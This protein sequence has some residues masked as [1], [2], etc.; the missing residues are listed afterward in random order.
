MRVICRVIGLPA[1]DAERLVDLV[2][3]TGEILAGIVDADAM[4]RAADAAMQ[5]GGYLA[6][7]LARAVDAAD[8]DGGTADDTLNALL[9]GEI[10]AGAMTFEEAAGILVQILSAG[11]ET[12]TSLIGQAVRVLAG[13]PVLQDR[14][15]TDPA[16]IAPFLEEVLRTD[17]PFRFHYRSTAHPTE[18]GGVAIPAGARLLLMWAAANLDAEGYADPDRLDVDRPLAKGHLAFGRGIHFCIGAP[19][20]RLEARIAVQRLLARTSAVALDPTV[21]PRHRPN[22]FLRRL[23]QLGVA[24][25]PS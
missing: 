24:L 21:P 11:S 18:L 1:Q 7:H 2:L 15:R 19:L 12:T 13:D 5:T 23:G 8:A 14:L 22:I 10:A 25:T 9:A 3:D 6:E 4:D 20:A 17:G 16:S